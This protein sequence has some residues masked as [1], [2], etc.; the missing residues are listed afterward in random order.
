MGYRLNQCLE[1]SLDY[2]VITIEDIVLNT[3]AKVHVLGINHSCFDAH[4]DRTE[5]GVSSVRIV[6]GP[7][8]MFVSRQ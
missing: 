1:V 2:F 4:M 5:L 6:M 7:I 3:L 8:C